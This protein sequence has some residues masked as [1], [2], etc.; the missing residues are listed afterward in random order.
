MPQTRASLLAASASAE[1]AEAPTEEELT[2][3]PQTIFTMQDREDGWND[4][5]GAIRAQ[6]DDRAKAWQQLSELGSRAN[7]QYLRP[8]AAVAKVLAEEVAEIVQPAVGTSIKP[9]D[10]KALDGQGLRQ[11]GAAAGLGLLDSIAAQKQAQKAKPPKTPAKP[12]APP[13]GPDV[14]PAAFNLGLLLAVPAATIGA[15]LWP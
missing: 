9:P 3:E 2:A 15:P 1:L 14:F 4:V 11:A 6:I 7:K 13:K 5:R 8:T 12:T 10:L